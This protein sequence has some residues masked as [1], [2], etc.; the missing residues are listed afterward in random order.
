MGPAPYWSKAYEAISH[1]NEAL[2]A[3][4]SIAAKD[5]EEQVQKNA[6]R[7]EAL[8]TR[9]FYHFNL[10]NI[11]GLHYSGSR[12]S[13]GV[14]HVLSPETTLYADYERETVHRNYEL[15]EKDMLEGIEL[16]DDSKWLASGKYH[17]NRNAALAFASRFYLYTRDFEKCVMYSDMMLGSTPQTYVRDFSSAVYT[18][19]SNSFDKFTSLFQSVKEQANLMIVAKRTLLT[20]SGIGYGLTRERYGEIFDNIPFGRFS[21]LRDQRAVATYLKGDDGL[22]AARFP[23]LFQRTNITSNTGFPYTAIAVFRGE[24]VPAQPC[25][26]KYSSWQ[27]RCCSRGFTDPGRSTLQRRQRLDC[28]DT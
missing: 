9:A 24:E 6:L 22:F 4:E 14:P 10:V 1:S 28:P 15:I 27:S 19:A 7:S 8:L 20:Y 11:F 17:F 25:G 23:N 3:L 26:G 12:N 16:V 13:P 21:G 5:E 18:S 2:L